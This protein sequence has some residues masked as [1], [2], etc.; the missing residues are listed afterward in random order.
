[1]PVASYPERARVTYTLV[2]LCTFFLSRECLPADLSLHLVTP[3]QTSRPTSDVTTSPT[4][5]QVTS[6]SSV[7]WEHLVTTLAGST[8]ILQQLV[9]VPWALTH[10]LPQEEGQWPAHLCV[11][12]VLQGRA[13]SKHLV[14]LSGRRGIEHWPG[15]LSVALVMLHV[16]ALCQSRLF[17]VGVFESP[18]SP[19]S[20]LQI[21]L[22][23]V[24]SVSITEATP[25]GVWQG[26]M[27]FL[28]WSYVILS[29]FLKHNPGRS[30]Q[31]SQ[32]DLVN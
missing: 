16:G 27:Y 20:L 3:T 2:L 12:S 15:S 29:M 6:P 5:G 13:H 11:P 21:L 28:A 25:P 14:N 31:R 1:M 7:G 4:S 32:A 19:H 18:F 8:C 26:E 23:F 22:L 17:P 30:A 24:N 9:S 10:Q